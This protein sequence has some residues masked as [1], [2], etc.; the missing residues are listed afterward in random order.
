VVEARV[1]TDG[2]RD[3]DF[4]F[5]PRS[6][7]VN[8]VLVI[9]GLCEKLLLIMVD[10]CRVSLEPPTEL[11]GEL[12]YP[13]ARRVL[14]DRVRPDVEVIEAG[15]LCFRDELFRRKTQGCHFTV[16][17]D[18]LN[19]I[20]FVEWPDDLLKATLQPAMLWRD[21]VIAALRYNGGYARILENRQEIF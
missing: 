5:P 21:E 2:L 8:N 7:V 12:A 14:H 11:L 9:T 20:A 1:F 19:E 17:V 6:A 10:E 3:A 13:L 4:E 18:K 15:G 16:G